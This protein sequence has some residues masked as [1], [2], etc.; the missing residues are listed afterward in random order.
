MTKEEKLW[1]RNAFAFLASQTLSLFGSSLVQYAIMWYLTLNT[2]SGIVMSSFIICGFLPAFFISPFAGVWADRF[3]RKRLIILADALIAVVTLAMAILFAYGYDY[4]WLLLLA[5]AARAV[6]T[7]MQTPAVGAVLPQIV[8]QDRLTRVNG[9]NSS[10]QA[11]ISFLSPMVSAL[12]LNYATMEIIFFV[13]V[14]TAAAA[15]VTLAALLDIP[16]HGKAQA[17]QVVSYFSD[18]R[19]GIAY[20]AGHPFL[21]TFFFFIACFFVCISPVA[22]LPPLQVARTFNSQVWHLTALEI[23]FSTGMLF[24]GLLL[25]FWGGLRNKN[26]TL[27]C[28]TLFFALSSFALGVVPVFWLY[29]VFYGLSGVA[30]PLFN[31]TATVLLQEKVEEDFLGRVFGVLNMLSTSM[32]PLGML[33]FGPVADFVRIELLMAVSGMLLLL[34]G[35][36]LLGSKKMTA[37]G[38]P[39]Q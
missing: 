7:G 18:L 38:A 13:D 31:T 6:G 21:K 34:Q 17:K 2:K 23:V 1:R 20:I 4:I 3:S 36:L 37:A 11:V 39:Q 15:I 29:L 33:F 9:I 30:M 32:L 27:A 35:V 25:T 24:G 12:L 8:P 19:Q 16:L 5:A 10:I 28:A 22:F 14:L 26:H